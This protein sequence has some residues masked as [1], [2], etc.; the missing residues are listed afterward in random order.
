MATSR[1]LKITDD[2]TAFAA[3]EKALQKELADATYKLEFVDWPKV[4]IRLNGPGYNSSITSDIAEAIVEIQTALNRAYSRLVHD[5]PDSRSLTAAERN[6]L[7]FKAKVSKGSSLINIDLGDFAKTLSTELLSKMTPDQLVISVLGLGAIAASV[8]AYKGYLKV[9]SDDRKSQIDADKQI[10]LSQE[11]TKRLDTLARAM[12]ANAAIAAAR[13]DFDDARNSL[14]KSVGDAKTLAVNDVT[15]DRDTARTLS[16]AKR[17]PSEE[18]QLNGTYMIL[19]TDLRA[20]DYIKL[21]VRRV[22][23][24]KEF[25]ATFQDNSLDRAQIGL[26]QSAEWGRTPV[27]LSINA[28]ILRGEVTTASIISVTAQPASAAR[29]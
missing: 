19:S 20:T 28:T 13:T 9:R 5:S 18:A 17:S 29:R 15:I 14:L 8:V 27:Y 6:N 11:E 26:L 21:R 23:D 4:T 24:E 25:S 12:S 7:R 1:T 3:L 16:L 10:A 2:K 22:Q